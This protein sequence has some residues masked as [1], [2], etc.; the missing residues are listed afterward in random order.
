MFSSNRKLIATILVVATVLSNAG[1]STLAA[2]ISRVTYDTKI[3]SVGDFIRY[4]QI[5]EQG[6]DPILRRAI[7]DILLEMNAGAFS[8]I[9]DTRRAQKEE[10]EAREKAQEEAGSQE[11]KAAGRWISGEAGRRAEKWLKHGI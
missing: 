3:A 7:G 8:I 5:A 9:K 1:F 10:A 2:S 4:I 11:T 6:E